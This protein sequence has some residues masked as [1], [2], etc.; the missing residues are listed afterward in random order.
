M[1]T[2]K[3]DAT[4]GEVSLARALL[5]EATEMVLAGNLDGS[6]RISRKIVD[7]YWSK[8]GENAATIATDAFEAYLTAARRLVKTHDQLDAFVWQSDLLIDK[9]LEKHDFERAIFFARTSSRI[10][11]RDNAQ[12]HSRTSRCHASDRNNQKTPGKIGH[13][14]KQ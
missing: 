4:R 11:R 2:P 12:R 9:L 14:L 6:L 7:R 13:G 3:K 8:T 10:C 1:E 5:Q